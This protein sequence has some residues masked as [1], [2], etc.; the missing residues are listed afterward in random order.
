MQGF[1]SPF[2]A[3]SFV[4]RNPSLVV[5]FVIPF[6]LS[7]LL[8]TGIGYVVYAH[9][10]PGMSSL[11][12]GGEWY[13]KALRFIVI[14][15]VT[16]LMAFVAIVSYSIV[17]TVL[18]APFND[19]L[20]EKV[21]KILGTF[22]PDAD[23]GV[24]GALLAAARG[25]KNAILLLLLLA[26]VMLALLLLNLVPL[27]GHALYTAMTFLAT[28]FFVGFQFFDFSL[29]RRRK[30]FR[31]K[32]SFNWANRWTAMGVGAGFLLMSLV[33]LVGFL[34]LNLATIGATMRA[35]EMI[36]GPGVNNP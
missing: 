1:W 13:M 20:S 24:T 19:L 3:F 27:V 12:S 9:V 31:Q 34:G 32:L 5:F 35:T 23:T 10:V 21:E 33:P 17:G 8:W 30:N 11:L 25:V 29:E 2:G 26:A 14:P 18:T 15:L 22:P 28:T 7:A 4:R 16:V 6:V 36:P